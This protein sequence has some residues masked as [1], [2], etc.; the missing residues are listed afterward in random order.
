VVEL[1]GTLFSSVEKYRDASY[2]ESMEQLG[3]EEIVW[4]LK[5]AIELGWYDIDSF[6]S[7]EYD[8][9]SSQ[10]DLSMIIPNMMVFSTPI[11]NGYDPSNNPMLQPADYS[12][13]L[14]EYKVGL[15]IRLSKAM[16]D[17]EGFVEHG[18]GHH[19]LWI[20]DHTEPS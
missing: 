14:S 1:F 10:Y 15:V 20:R 5:I 16:Y 9:L 17:G 3:V 13:I 2:G 19:D 4:G 7:S 6:D 11:D 12:T 8:R 18:I